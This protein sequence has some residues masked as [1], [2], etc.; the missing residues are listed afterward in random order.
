MT[1]RDDDIT[2]ENGKI[3]CNSGKYNP[4]D[5]ERQRD[6]T[7]EYVKS[8]IHRLTHNYKIFKTAQEKYAVDAM[9]A[10]YH[11]LIGDKANAEAYKAKA[12]AVDKSKI[13]RDEQFEKLDKLEKLER[14]L[15]AI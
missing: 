3:V 10:I 2:V 8:N 7:I 15:K 6:G 13:V 5:S 1:I 14:L 4:F 11:A 12:S 9:L